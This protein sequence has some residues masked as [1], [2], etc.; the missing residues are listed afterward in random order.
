MAE[1]ERILITGGMGF[2]G[3]RL[4]KVLEAQ[5]EILSLD[6]LHPQIHGLIG[7]QFHSRNIVGSVADAGKL[8]QVV[9]YFNPTVIYHLA[10]ETGTGQSYDEPV[11]YCDV[12]IQGTVN[13]IEAARAGAKS[14]RRVVVAGSRSVYGEG[15]YRDGDRIVGG[16]P[17]E[18]ATMAAGNF[19]VMSEDGRP[20]E[21]V[22]TPE[23]LPPRPTSVYATSKLA[24]EYLL[25]QCF[26][27][28]D[29]DVICLR[30]QNVYGA[31]QSLSNPYTGV[32][33]IMSQIA[34]DGRQ[35][36]VFEDG[37]IARDF[38]HVSDVVQALALVSE[39]GQT[40]GSDPINIG[41]G[42]PVTI[43]EMASKLLE[44]LGKDPNNYHISGDFRAGDVRYAVADIAR[45]KSVLGWSAQ[46]SFEDGMKEIAEWVIAERLKAGGSM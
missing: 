32:I 20:L 17:R 11:R 29:V 43:T 8:A 5:H 28:T 14:L 21:P 31:G 13:L 38:V 24:Q 19:A 6:C 35:L 9:R 36:N 41:S 44:L 37:A 45:A 12:N 40:I 26:D 34:L 42:R 23:W 33:S 1:R 2:I 25:K 4:V 39:P 22:P 16:R 3:S 7:H 46:V 30:F 18:S 15:A 27:G 10:A